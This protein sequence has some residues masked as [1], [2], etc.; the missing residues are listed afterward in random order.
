MQ[1]KTFK[2]VNMPEALRMVKSEFG[3]DAMI[4]SSRKERR[5]GLLGRF[6]KPYFE[7]MAALDNSPRVN[8]EARP[9]LEKS[10]PNTMEAFQNSMLAPMA[11]ELKELRAQMESLKARETGVFRQSPSPPQNYRK[12]DR[13]IPEVKKTAPH[14]LPI[15]EVEELKKV[16]LR[17]MER[18]EVSVKEKS[19]GQ[20]NDLHS[21]RGSREVAVLAEELQANGVEQAVISHLMIPVSKAAAQGETVD[22]LRERLNKL[23]AACIR[24]SG[25]A[26]EVKNSAHILA[27]VGPTGV[28]KTTTIAK[29]AALAY[30]QGI[31]VAL[32]TIDTFRIGAVAQLQTYS[33][34]MDIPMEI[35]A[36]PA[37]LAE[38]IAAHADKKLI[39]IDTAGRNHQDPNKI[40]EM[41]AFLEVNPAIET[42]LCLSATTRDRELIQAVTRFGALPISRVLFTK[43]DESMSYGCIVNTHLRNKLPL[44]YFTT[45]QRVPE[46]IEI[47]TSQK[48][49]ELVLRGMKS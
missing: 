10:E 31:P 37:A 49:A 41:K 24:C 13:E 33:E 6:Y 29:L 12:P 40:L 34:I 5:N 42:H 23:L 46:D 39:F 48:V 4:L 1:V 17:P 3:P 20:R 15:S 30:K 7:V 26:M 44:S 38:A 22:Q 27:L 16:L 21:L 14:E 45:G 25:Q 28:G 8:H 19:S 35:A 9:E 2:A 18:A 36:T 47:A 11:R 32:I 43:L